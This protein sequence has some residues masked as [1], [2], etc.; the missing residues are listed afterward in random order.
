V[1]TK[2]I[3]ILI[4]AF[5]LRLIFVPVVFH[6]DVFD[7]LNW[8]KDL[9]RNGLIGFY[10]RDIPDAGDPNYPPLY[11]LT[12]YANNSVYLLSR[13]VMWGINTKVK[14]FP[15]QFYLWY[16]S[17]RGRI[18]FN[19]LLPIF[20]DLAIGYLIYLAVL[21]L[22]D[23]KS[24][25]I[26]L[27]LFL[28]LPP[29]WYLSSVWGQ[30]DSIYLL[31]L[32]GSVY[33]LF[34]DKKITLSILLFT[35]S[36]LIK[37]TA[38]LLAPIYLTSLVD[39]VNKDLFKGVILSIILLFA[40]GL[41]FGILPVPSQIINFYVYNIREI[42][43]YVTSNTFNLWGII[44]GFGTISDQTLWFGIKSFYLGALFTLVFWI[45]YSVLI[46]KEK[47]LELKLLTT[48]LIS[49]SAFLFLTRMHERY[50]YLTF[51]LLV[52]LGSLYKRTAFVLILATIIF[53]INLYHFWWVPG[54]DLFKYILSAR[55]VEIG[56]CLLNLF[57][58]FYLER[59][60][61]KY[62]NG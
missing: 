15:S 58:F 27:S 2:L 28:F 29:S 23:N 9:E 6:K 20:C 30:T 12:I 13:N 56:F 36:F 50:F 22:R 57:T 26:A 35:I 21:K 18:A 4:L 1:K 25:A 55:N 10:D 37:P 44:F 40:V 17:N 42:Q 54:G 5:V 45:Y 34:F 31:P 16:E 11:F 61:V 46:F 14:I 52:I 8:A 32:L 47:K 62:L 48:S 41:P 24:A 49:Y 59:L 33:F 7:Q 38:V 60:R 53:S 43:G 3:I 39:G 51:I 19:K